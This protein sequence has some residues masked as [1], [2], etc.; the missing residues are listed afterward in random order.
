MT[1]ALIVATYVL[2]AMTIGA[3]IGL[4]A[5]LQTGTLAGCVT[6]LLFAQFDASLARRRDKTAQAKAIAGL[7]GAGIAMERALAES[8]DRV[9]ALSTTIE[10]RTT[11][12][13][14]K[15]VSELKMLESLMR[16]FAGKISNKAREV[17]RE[18]APEAEI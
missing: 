10:T 15:V 9:D 4:F 14:R 2:A 12:Q 11:E 13:S 16:E 1:K 7:R 8:R 6:F 5:G 17:I 18:A 3:A